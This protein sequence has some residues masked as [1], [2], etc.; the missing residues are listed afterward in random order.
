VISLP[1]K[2]LV[3]FWVMGDDRLHVLDEA[4]LDVASAVEIELEVDHGGLN[5]VMAQA[6]FDICD[7]LAPME[8]IHGPAVPEGVDRVDV[9]KTFLG[10]GLGEMLLAD[11]IDAVAGEGLSP[12]TD[13]KMVLIKGLWG[14]TIF[15]YIETQELRG[16]LL[17][18]DQSEPVSLSQDGQGILLGVEGVEVEGG[19]L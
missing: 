13:K 5:V 6:V 19:D 7:G 3:Y 11:A 15:L 8:K 16:P 14:E 4:A 18:L 12:L 17:D 10:Q 9:L 2:E 1:L